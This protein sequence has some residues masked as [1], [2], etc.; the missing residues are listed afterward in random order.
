MMMNN[1]PMIFLN[2]FSKIFILLYVLPTLDTAYARSQ[3]KIM[4]GMPVAIAKSTGNR[5]PELPE[6]VNGI[7]I[8]KYKT[9]LYGQNAIAKSTP[10][11]KAPA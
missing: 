6:S 3:E 4:T 11:K 1:I 8:P 2:H 5:S 10:S 7:S 9:P